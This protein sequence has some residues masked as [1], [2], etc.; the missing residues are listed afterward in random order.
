MPRLPFNLHKDATFRGPDS[1]YFDPR[2]PRRAPVRSRDLPHLT[3]L[4]P[5]PGDPPVTPTENLLIAAVLIL[6]A[7]TWYAS[8]LIGG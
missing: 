3:H 6:L 5:G 4:K 2:A 7:L 8:W 1:R